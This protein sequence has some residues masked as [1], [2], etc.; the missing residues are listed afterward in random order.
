MLFASVVADMT[1]VDVRAL[2]E[3]QKPFLPFPK[4]ASS[5][6]K[7]KK[8]PVAWCELIASVVAEIKTAYRRVLEESRKL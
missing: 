7:R 2:E 1:T 4:F 3:V 5:E 6:G 8:S